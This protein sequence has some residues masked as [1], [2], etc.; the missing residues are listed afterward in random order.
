MGRNDKP[1]P[2]T[3]SAVLPL[4]PRLRRARQEAGIR[5]S[6]M[7]N[8]IGFTKGHLSGVENRRVRP[9][10]ELVKLYEREIGLTPGALL[11]VE[12][13]TMGAL[14]RRRS[15][16]SEDLWGLLEEGVSADQSARSPLDEIKHLLDQIQESRDLS[17]EDLALIAGFIKA[18]L[19]WLQSREGKS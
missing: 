19:H 4:G 6:E 13:R 12:D 10:E 2:P 18:G 9:S 11:Q 5:L 15:P 8:R 14:G 7:A 16:I 17:T 3:D 1:I